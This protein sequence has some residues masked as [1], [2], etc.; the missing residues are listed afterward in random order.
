GQVPE[1]VFPVKSTSSIAH[2]CAPIPSAHAPRSTAPEAICA[3]TIA[4]GA[5]R[6]RCED[7]QLVAP[8]GPWARV[9]QARTDR[10][11]AF[12]SAGPIPWVA[13]G[14]D[15]RHRQKPGSG[16]C[17]ARGIRVA[18]L[19][20]PACARATFHPSLASLESGNRGDALRTHIRAPPHEPDTHH[21]GFHDDA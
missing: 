8:P 10:N 5:R 14:C 1:Q 15:A 6:I 16:A 7:Y 11:A 3:K 20:L 19:R 18:L 9:D 17:A 12:R 2:A 4:L 13:G 21:G